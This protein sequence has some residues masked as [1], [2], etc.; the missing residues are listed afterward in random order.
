MRKK[1][2]KGSACKHDLLYR[3]PKDVTRTVRLSVEFS[4]VS[5]YKINIQNISYIL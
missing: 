2:L 1:D 3:V 4:E 5:G